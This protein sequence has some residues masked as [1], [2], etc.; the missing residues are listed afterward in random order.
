MGVLGLF[1]LRWSLL[2]LP[3]LVGAPESEITVTSSAWPAACPT[4]DAMGRRASAHLATWSGEAAAE[5]RVQ[6]S[7]RETD[8]RWS[9]AISV[10]VADG[11]TERMFEADTCDDAVEAMALIVAT[12]I[13]PGGPSS[14]PPVATHDAD[15]VEPEP[16]PP[17]PP[18]ELPLVQGP[19]VDEPDD[20]TDESVR[21]SDPPPSA[22]SGPSTR[23]RLVG[24]LH[25]GLAFGLLPRVGADL[26]GWIGLGTKHAEFGTSFRTVTPRT[27]RRNGDG[28]RFT[29]WMGG[30]RA[31]ARSAKRVQVGGCGTLEAGGTTAQGVGFVLNDR[32]TSLWTG[33]GVSA[34][35]GY[36]LEKLSLRFEPGLVVGFVR[37]EFGGEN[38]RFDQQ[39][40]R[41]GLRANFVVHFEVP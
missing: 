20:P 37:P 27:I 21:A 2:G 19:S 32:A 17:A 29:L 35:I 15:A 30:L 9:V 24:G 4:T 25:A 33:A 10:A 1:A 40:G 12:A 5:A 7:I 41:L 6:A 38:S 39:V 26:G 28:G 31:C 13:N 23:V 34:W 22:A 18:P 14:L 16:T 8:G 11:T 3:A 36:R